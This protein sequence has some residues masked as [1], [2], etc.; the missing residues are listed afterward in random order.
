[1]HYRSIHTDYKILI[2]AIKPG[3][4]LNNVVELTM[5]KHMSSIHSLIASDPPTVSYYGL[6]SCTIKL[7]GLCL[8]I[9][10]VFMI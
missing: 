9:V 1:M 7:L 5:T 6:H 10:S 4:R 8:C 2:K 3:Y